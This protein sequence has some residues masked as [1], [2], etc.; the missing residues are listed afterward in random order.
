M[1]YLINTGR[2]LLRISIQEFSGAFTVQPSIGRSL[3]AKKSQTLKFFLALLA[4]TGLDL[5]MD[6]KKQVHVDAN[7]LI[8]VAR[9]HQHVV[10]THDSPMEAA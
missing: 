6:L 10:I 3:D 8:H 9:Q 5:H 7:F 4:V 1:T 2:P